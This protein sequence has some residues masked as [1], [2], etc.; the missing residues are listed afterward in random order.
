MQFPADFLGVSGHVAI[1]I[2]QL[3]GGAS[4]SAHGAG[5]GL[6]SLPDLGGDMLSGKYFLVLE[7]ILDL[8]WPVF[9]VPDLVPYKT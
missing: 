5:I 7:E 3:R 8:L 2:N 4:G 9:D 6:E 1:R